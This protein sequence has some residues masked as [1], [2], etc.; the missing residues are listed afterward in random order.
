MLFIFFAGLQNQKDVPHYQRKGNKGLDKDSDLACE[1]EI[2]IWLVDNGTI[3]WF[4][5]L[6]PK[7][8]KISSRTSMQSYE[9]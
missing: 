5:K 4:L 6:Q 7:K 8:I 1:T 2:L 3:G 9:H